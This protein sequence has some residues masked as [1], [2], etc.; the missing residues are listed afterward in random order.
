MGTPPGGI[1]SDVLLLEERMA[2]GAKAKTVQPTTIHPQS[3]S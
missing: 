3:T 2:T 1:R